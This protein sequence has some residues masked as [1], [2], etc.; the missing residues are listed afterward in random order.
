M[1]TPDGG[2]APSRG[3]FWVREGGVELRP[4][5]P[6]GNAFGYP[7]RHLIRRFARG[8]VHRQTSRHTQIRGQ[9]CMDWCIP[10]PPVREGLGLTAPASPLRLA[11]DPG[12]SRPGLWRSRL[13]GS[14][15]SSFRLGGGHAEGPG[16]AGGL[17]CFI[18]VAVAI[19]YDQRGSGGGGRRR[20]TAVVYSGDSCTAPSF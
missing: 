4:E 1:R 6:Q 18:P 12:T 10:A 19:G 13:S 8:D 20:L 14:A 9:L 5:D 11:Q 2:I 16:G 15:S 3:V 7:K 17:G